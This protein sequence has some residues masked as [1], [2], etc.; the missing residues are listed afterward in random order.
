[1]NDALDSSGAPRGG[2]S[3]TWAP[4][5]DA[6]SG[7]ENATARALFTP[8]HLRRV[9]LKNRIVRSATYEGRG[10]ANG[11]PDPGLADLYTE[12]A[13]GGVGAIITGFA[14]ISQ[15]GRA[16]QPRQCGIESDAKIAPWRRIV[17]R[18]KA[19]SPDVRL[20]MQIAHCGRQTTA[21]AT[22]L[23]VVGVSSRRCPYFRQRVRVLDSASIETIVTQFG[24]AARRAREA[25]FDGVQIHA[26]HGYLI[27]QFLSP[28]TNTRTDRWSKPTLFLEEVVR[29]VRVRCGNAFPVLVKL[30]AA[31][32]GGRGIR[33]EDTIRTARTL[34]ELNVDAVEVSYG[35]MELGL[36][37][38]RGA[39]PVD[40]VLESNPLFS[41]IP[42]VMRRA[43]KAVC[44]PAYLRR[45]LPFEEGYNI[46]AAARLRRATSIP[47]IP[48]GG[49]RSLKT[50]VKCLEANRLDGVALCRPLICEPDLPARLRDG[51]ATSSKCC[52]CNLCTVHCDTPQPT[53]CYAHRRPTVERRTP[54]G[55][56]Q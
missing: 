50:M 1:M 42:A 27:H 56:T 37:I 30:S 14:F 18:V 29:A 51:T 15:E 10:D 2:R 20:F 34:Q 45:L 48:V 21:K 52:N 44:L 16:M 26:A 36:N 28:W 24:E 53:R 7:K 38:I 32:D 4:Q 5:G 13:Q 17:T 35:T 22:G 33:L 49:I 39:C 8:L 41:R 9:T 25:G 43:W 11:T 23:P 19:A 6:R 47:V 31:E 3:R 40:A 46:A 54:P 55:P 12:L